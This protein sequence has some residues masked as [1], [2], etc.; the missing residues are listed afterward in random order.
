MGKIT[1]TIMKIET[2]HNDIR[3][4]L[5]NDNLKVGDSVYPI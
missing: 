5:S 3:Y 4:T 1:Q 2:V